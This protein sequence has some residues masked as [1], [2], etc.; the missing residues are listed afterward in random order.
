MPKG[1]YSN[2]KC[3]VEQHPLFKPTPHQKEALKAFMVNKYK[4]ML[5]YWKLGAG[6][7]CGAILIA[8]TLLRQRSVNH[9]YILSS[10]SLRQG[11]INEYC[12]VCGY[13]AKYMKKYF[14][15]VTYNYMVGDHLPN[16]NGSLVII[17]EVHN[18]INGVKNGSPHP[19]K[20]YKKL[21]GSDCRILALSGTP[22]YHYVY[23]FALLGNL[24]KPGYFPKIR[25]DTGDIDSGAF[26]LAFFTEDS[27]G[28]LQFKNPTVGKRLLEGI[29]SYYPGSGAEYV[30]E[31]L[32]QEPIKVQMAPEQEKNYWISVLQE[33]KLSRPPSKKLKITDPKRYELLKKLYIMATKKILRRSTANFNYPP[34][35]PKNREQDIPREEGGWINRKIFRGG[36]L[37]KFFSPKF[38]A[39]LFNI[40][41]HNLQKHV[42]FTF[43]KEKAGVN[44]LKTLLNMCGIKAEIFSGDLNDNQRRE[45]LRR[46]NAPEN[47]YGD[48]IRVLLVTEAGGEGI[49]LLDTRHMHII[50]SSPRVNKIIQ[51]IG[52]V[53]RYKSHIKLPPEERKV[54]VWRYWSVASPGPV[55]ITA[56]VNTPEGT[57]EKETRVI[58]DKTAIDEVLY[59]KGKKTE[60][61]INS[62][63]D[64]LKNV[65][66]TPWR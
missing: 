11:W 8:D 54:R 12:R 49:S 14:T 2:L 53:A 44:L 65:S 3:K 19:S 62:F 50:E 16:F 7:T 36:N 39:V 32:E 38:T 60:Q 59:Q 28:T 18:L 10:G 22:V 26:L 15:F 58:T 23:E 43:F 55:R 13:K 45:L 63:L 40:V 37:Y 46:F 29:I 1:I 6:K 30:P 20:I 52:R 33:N 24:L 48:K 56:Q 57:I 61:R 4:G 5:L 25:S 41:M 21:M 31:I 66:V 35:I 9:V 64:L 47:R 51:A 27:N 34:G 17:D 42:V